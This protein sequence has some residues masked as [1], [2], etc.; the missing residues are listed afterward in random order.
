MPK[1]IASEQAVNRLARPSELADRAADLS[2]YAAP[3]ALSRAC[4]HHQHGALHGD[5]AGAVQG[6]L[7]RNSREDALTS[8]L[9]AQTRPLTRIGIEDKTLS[10]S[11]EEFL[12]PKKVDPRPFVS[13]ESRSTPPGS[14]ASYDQN[15]MKV[16]NREPLGERG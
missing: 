1:D 16:L 9:Q 3:P 4:P 14:M 12:E 15:A 6:Y 5:V 2:P 11:F 10:I 8:I 7:V 13:E